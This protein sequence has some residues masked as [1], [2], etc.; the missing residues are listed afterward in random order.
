MYNHQIRV[1][2]KKSEYRDGTIYAGLPSSQGFG[3][4]GQSCSTF[5]LP[6]QCPKGDEEGLGS[7]NDQEILAALRQERAE[8]QHLLRLIRKK[9]SARFEAR[10]LQDLPRHWTGG[11]FIEG[12]MGPAG[13]LEDLFKVLRGW[14]ELV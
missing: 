11:V 5:C 10:T 13:N 12:R 3:V 9:L 1:D 14:C 2:S 7:E 8:R 6:Q 4:G